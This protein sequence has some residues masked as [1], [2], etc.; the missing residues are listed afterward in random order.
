MVVIDRLKKSFGS[1]EALKG[2]SLTVPRGSCF[3]LLGPN[4]AGKS[5]AI[6]IIVGGLK[7]DSGTVTIDGLTLKGEA[8]PLLQRI[9]Y[10]PQEIALFG[11][12]KADQNLR[13]FGSLYGLDGKVLESRTQEALEFVGLLD[14]AKDPV[15]GYSGGMKRRLNIA[16]ALLH[17]PD[18]II[19][20][21]PTVGVDAQ[22]RNAIFDTLEV[23]KGEGN[24]LIYTTHYMEEVER[25]CDR[26][27]IIDHGSVRAEG[28]L[29]ELLQTL[30][31]P[32]SLVLAFP[33][34]RLRNSALECLYRFSPAPL[35]EVHLEAP[36]A[37]FGAAVVEVVSTL[38]SAGLAPDDLSTRR[39]NLEQV[40]LNVTGRSIRD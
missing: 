3:G 13:F 40:F 28:T 22:S 18:L 20:D 25:M 36:V 11:E 39:G 32:K 24:T 16:A 30:A 31:N 27:A 38:Q 19:F 6:S 12:L 2:V 9:G 7:Q 35:N 5:T 37:D 21:E 10:V 17:H 33:S 34:A 26:I 8:D 23:L 29:H 4:G 14:R 1:V 15:K